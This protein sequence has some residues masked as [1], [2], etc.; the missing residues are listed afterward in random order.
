V[1]WGEVQPTALRVEKAFWERSKLTL[2]PTNGQCLHSRHFVRTESQ[3]ANIRKNLWHLE[4]KGCVFLVLASLH[5]HR[6]Q[7]RVSHPLL[8]S[9]W[10]RNRLNERE[11]LYSK[12]RG[13][14]H[15]PQLGAGLAPQIDVHTKE[16]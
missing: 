9:K 6:A 16:E 12:M 7:H 3:L 1:I 8:L 13:S 14:S 10:V 5:W 15:L 11:A 2:G 4:E